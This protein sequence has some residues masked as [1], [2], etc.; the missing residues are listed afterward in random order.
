MVTLIDI[1]IL[2]F[3]IHADAFTLS[4]KN[5]VA[6]YWGQN[7]AG[8][9]QSLGY[10]CKDDTVDIIILS[11]LTTFGKGQPLVVN[12]ANA[13]EGSYLSGYPSLLSCPAIGADI[14]ACQAAG[15]LII[16]SLGGATGSYGFSDDAD[17]KAVASNLHNL[18][19]KGSSPNKVFGSASVDGFD[20]DIESGGSNGYAALINTLRSLD[21]SYII[22]G[23]PQCPKPDA[24]LDV[25]MQSSHYDILFVQF[26]N[27]Y[28]GVSGTNFNYGD[29][30]SYGEQ[31]GT[32]IYVGLASSASA[33]NS[34]SYVDAAGL[35]RIIDNVKGQ[36]A[37]GGIM[38][39]DASQAWANNLFQKQIKTIIGLNPVT[40]GSGLNPVTPGSGLNPVTPPSGLNPATPIHSI[41]T[42]ANSNSTP[43]ADT[44]TISPVIP[45]A[46]ITDA[47][48]Q[49]QIAQTTTIRKTATVYMT[50]S[51]VS[52][53]VL[54]PTPSIRN[55][56]IAPLDIARTNFAI[57]TSTILV[58]PSA[59]TTV[60]NSSCQDNAFICKGSQIGHCDHGVWLYTTCPGTGICLEG[61]FVCSAPAKLRKRSS[62]KHAGRWSRKSRRVLL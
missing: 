20:M 9:Q 51:L 26:Y 10:Y 5:N 45:S 30:E 11:F 57:S 46:T 35:T 41:D 43:S 47:S 14:K 34:G 3:I 39:W 62:F 8:N 58:Y 24:N 17:A 12:F 38:L 6:V 44:A 7:S 2:F 59:T 25:S 49:N 1:L 29:W 28:C 50:R 36:N 53:A 33:A 40:P 54:V 13:C 37:F 32:K 42:D 21:S 22:T 52:G 55:K 19:G 16:L 61:S 4:A 27:N 31:H 23:A 60:I 56:N 48:P 18:F 15:K